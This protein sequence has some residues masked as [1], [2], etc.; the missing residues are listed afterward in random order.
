MGVGKTGATLTYLSHLSI[1]E[2][3][4]LP[5]LV[6]APQR[7]AASVWPA[8]VKE[9]DHLRDLRVSAIIG[10]KAQREAALRRKADVYTINYENLPWLAGRL[11]DV[12]PFRTVVADESVRLK[13]HRSHFR[14]E[15]TGRRTLIRTG[16]QRGRA[17]AKPAIKNVTRWVNLTGKPAPNG[18][19]D[20][21]GQT[22]FLDFGQRLGSHYDAFQQRY[23]RAGYNGYGLEP[24]DHAQSEIEA[25]LSDICLT[26]LAKDFFDLPPI[27]ENTLWVELPPVARKIYDDMEDEMFAELHAGDVEAFNAAGKT[28]KTHQICNGAVIHD[29]KGT[30]E[31]VHKEKLYALESVIEE[32]AGMP[33][34]VAYHF[35]SDLARLQ[36][37]FPKGR[38]LDKNPRTIVE[39]NAGK[40]PI[41]FA[42][43]A[44]CGHGLNLQH[45]SNILVFFSIDWNLDNHEQIIERIGPMRQFQ[46][47]IDRPT[48]LHYILAKNTIDEVIRERLISKRT[49]QELLLEAMKHRKKEK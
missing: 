28:S 8:E 4:A 33:V 27:I 1:L 20:L 6:L 17:L 7:V 26:L 39:W 41:L 44:S 38:Q 36:K 22:W 21:W 11:G 37:A 40:I 10:P 49:V 5:A 46:A 29:D 43:P 19:Q 42:H 25:R 16:G 2:R 30:W 47:G 45:G 14:I 23:F 31:E 18:L 9:W 15:T 35:K 32:A 3:D 34:L 13:S 12:W 48:F 24:L